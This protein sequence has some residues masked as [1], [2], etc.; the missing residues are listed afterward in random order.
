M[1]QDKRRSKKRKVILFY[2]LGINTRHAKN[3]V[4]TIDKYK[5][6]LPLSPFFFLREIKKMLFFL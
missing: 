1:K 6:Q 3:N 4:A 5:G 2:F